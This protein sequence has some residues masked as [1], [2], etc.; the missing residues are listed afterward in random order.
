MEN[1][2][3][4]LQIVPFILPP[5]GNP[6]EERVTTIDRLANRKFLNTGKFI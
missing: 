4:N 1:L 6:T 2:S 3:S 5:A